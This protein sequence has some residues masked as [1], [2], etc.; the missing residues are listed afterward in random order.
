MKENKRI[1]GVKID[2]M[3]D[4]TGALPEGLVAWFNVLPQ[5]QRKTVVRDLVEMI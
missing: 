4:L 2:A 3:W 1:T 5:D